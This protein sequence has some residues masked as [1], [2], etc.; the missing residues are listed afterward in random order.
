[1]A[2]DAVPLAGNPFVA[3]TTPCTCVG[4]AS[5][6]VPEPQSNIF[7]RSKSKESLPFG[8]SH[9][10]ML[11][12]GTGCG[13]KSLWCSCQWALCDM[14][15]FCVTFKRSPSPWASFTT[16]AHA[17]FNTTL[18]LFQWRRWGWF[19]VIKKTNSFISKS[20]WRN[21]YKTSSVNIMPGCCFLP[22]SKRIHIR[23]I[24]I[25]KLS[26]SVCVCV[27][28]STV[29]VLWWTGDLPWACFC[30]SPDLYKCYVIK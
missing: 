2:A 25:S 29:C 23:L 14:E 18:V 9:A 12:P 1:M 8:L 21:P 5:T 4:M 20:P 15:F 19:Y 17:V 3:M 10:I 7:F 22:R 11:E 6:R 26:L 28:E 24:R 13:R 27:R 16:A 30:P